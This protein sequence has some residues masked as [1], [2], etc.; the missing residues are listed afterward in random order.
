[1]ISNSFKN[2]RGTEDSGGR[3]IKRSINIDINFVKFC[4]EEMLNR[5]EKF[6]HLS[7][8]IRSKREEVSKHNAEQSIDTSQIINGRRLTN[9]GTFRAYLVH[10]LRKHPK[11]DQNM[12]FLVRH[13]PL[14]ERGLPIEIYIFS[15]VQAWA[16]YEDIQADIMDHILAVMPLF[17]LRAFQN[18]T[19]ND[20]RAMGVRNP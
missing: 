6:E 8:Y 12:T 14:T 2:W 11:I 17:D 16:A 15:K 19:G 5:F 20:F 1:M 3:R 9:V 18:P 10:Y 4:S 13:R 7:D